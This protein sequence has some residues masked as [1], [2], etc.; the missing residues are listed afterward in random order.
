ME[1]GFEM[2]LTLSNT[3]FYLITQTLV[4]LKKRQEKK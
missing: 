3:F 2:T 1:I 4:I